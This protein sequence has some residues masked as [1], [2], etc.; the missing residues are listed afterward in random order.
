MSLLPL[1]TLSSMLSCFLA[2]ASRQCWFQ[3]TCVCVFH[4]R[5]RWVNSLPKS[6]AVCDCRWLFLWINM[7]IYSI[8]PCYLSTKQNVETFL[9]FYL[10]T[11]LPCY[12]STL[13]PCYL[14]TLLHCYLS[15]FLPRYLATRQNMETLLPFYL[16]TLLPDKAWR[17]CYHLL[18]QL[19]TVAAFFPH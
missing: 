9:P 12:L 14:A 8:L 15:T 13:L 17:P 4:G 16:S 5:P 18:K 6:V 1:E 19:P 3:F 10:A 11:F 7:C 2:K